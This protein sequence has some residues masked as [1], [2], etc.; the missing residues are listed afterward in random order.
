MGSLQILLDSHSTDQFRPEQGQRLVISVPSD[1]QTHT[2]EVSYYF[3]R[4]SLGFKK[5]RIQLPYI[6]ESKWTRWL[7][8]SLCVPKNIHL[9]TPPKALNAEYSWQRQ[10][11]F[12]RRN[13][14]YA[15][16]A[17]EEWSGG[18]NLPDPPQGTNIYLFS[19]FGQIENVEVTLVDRSLL[20]ALSSLIVLILGL[21]II[22]VKRLRKI[23]TLTLLATGLLFASLWEP[24]IALTILQASALGCALLALSFMFRKRTPSSTRMDTTIAQI[25]SSRTHAS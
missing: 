11:P 6:E 1:E 7:Y 22:H 5:E 12:F 10:G 20:T 13:S 8:W 15:F 25:G 14:I 18:R 21:I 19:G 16:S 2:L 17:L 23:W 9:L 3:M 24:E 4:S